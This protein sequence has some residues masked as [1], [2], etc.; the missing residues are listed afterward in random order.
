MAEIH[1]EFDL[2]RLHGLL[3]KVLQAPFEL[4]RYVA[5]QFKIGM[6]ISLKRTL[7]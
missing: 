2:S 7:L 3:A 4:K 5:R 6:I 1:S